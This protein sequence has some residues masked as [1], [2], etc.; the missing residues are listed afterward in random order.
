MASLRVEGDGIQITLT[1]SERV[2]GLLRDL[3][4]PTTSIRSVEV[5]PNGRAAVRG[6]RAPANPATAGA[7]MIADTPPSAAPPAPRPDQPAGDAA[8]DDSN[9]DGYIARVERELKQ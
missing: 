6:M 4:I 7:T 8:L 5:V 9:L 3:R 1:P 2:F